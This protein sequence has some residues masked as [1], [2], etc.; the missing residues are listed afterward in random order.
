MLTQNLSPLSLKK[1][2]FSLEHISSCGNTSG[3]CQNEKVD[4]TTDSPDEENAC[5][6]EVG[7]SYKIFSQNGYLNCNKFSTSI[8]DSTIVLWPKS[9][10]KNQEWQFLPVDEDGREK[11]NLYVIVCMATHKA[12]TVEEQPGG[13][14]LLRQWS[15]DTPDA[16]QQFRITERNNNLCEIE[17]VQTNQ[18][19]T[20]DSLDGHKKETNEVAVGL[21]PKVRSQNELSLWRLS[22]TGMSFHDIY[23]SLSRREDSSK[24]KF[25]ACMSVLH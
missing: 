2:L 22:K 9:E 10:T 5:K 4:S 17:H 21:A 6:P 20:I 8:N 7:Q 16:N 14:P 15:H 3:Y 12:L 11:T 1:H 19:I 25:F 24:N 18:T 23:Y 13:F